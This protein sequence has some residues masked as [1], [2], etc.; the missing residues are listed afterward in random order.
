MWQLAAALLQLIGVGGRPVGAQAEAEAEAA[1]LRTFQQT[2]SAAAAAP[3]GAAQLGAAL[4]SAANALLVGL[5]ISL[6]VISIVGNCLVCVAIFTERKLRKL[7][8]AFIV[9]LAIADLFVSCLVMTFALCNELMSYWIF[10]DWF[11]DVWIS[12][13]IMCST[14]SIL[15]LCAISLDRFILIKDCLLYNQWMTRKVASV[16]LLLIW[17]ISALVS[18]L[19][20]FLGWHKPKAG[21]DY[22]SLPASLPASS[23]Q[24][25]SGVQD[26]EDHDN[27]DGRRPLDSSGGA[28]DA[29]GGRRP[30]RASSANKTASCRDKL[31][32]SGGHFAA[33]S[34]AA[35]ETQSSPPPP[36]ATLAAARAAQVAPRAAASNS[37]APRAAGSVSLA[38]GV[39]FAWRH[40]RARRRSR[41]RQPR[42]ANQRRRPA[43]AATTIDGSDDK[44]APLDPLRP[45]LVAAARPTN[46]AKRISGEPRRR[47]QAQADL[48]TQPR[49]VGG[50]QHEPAPLGWPLGAQLARLGAESGQPA[51]SPGLGGSLAASAPALALPQCQLSLTPTYAIVSST[52]SFYIPCII[53]IGLYTKLFACARR[54]VKSIQSISRAPAPRVAAD[55]NCSSAAQ[56][57]SLKQLHRAETANN[58]TAS[59]TQPSASSDLSSLGTGGGGGGGVATASEPTV[60]LAAGGN[61]SKP[62]DKN[63]EAETNID[64]APTAGSKASGRRRS[65]NQQRQQQQV[66]SPETTKYGQDLSQTDSRGSRSQSRVAFAAAGGADETQPFVSAGDGE[67]ETCELAKTTTTTIAADQPTKTTGER[68]APGQ[69]QHQHQNQHQIQ[70]R[71]A[72]GQQKQHIVQHQQQHGGGGGHLATHKAAITLGI[73]MGT[74]L[75]CW[76]PFFCLNIIKAF[77]GDCIP[78]SVFRFFTWLGYANSALNPIIYGIHNSEFRSAFNRVFFK[79]LRPKQN[80][81]A[82]PNQPSSNGGRRKQHHQHLR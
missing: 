76:V 17:F 35:I 41:R 8:N 47:R 75:F 66:H 36:A 23:R 27:Q 38:A 33:G 68:P 61:R 60:G 34:K 26:H 64:R 29:T 24:L 74:F 54:H 67:L 2:D 3:S 20:I 65:S 63:K 73:I 25:A 37:G 44:Q 5:L 82:G 53:M 77:C 70:F 16:A 46:Q 51:A 31:N 79:H 81:L 30:K 9:S 40:N 39:D 42:K 1:L 32:Y 55:S 21:T 7:G 14:A 12:F 6:I 52:I 15:N 57:C 11:C 28:G 13:D 71:L 18:F 78:G 45:A 4:A 69:S 22:A 56:S 58:N 72:S 62:A 10:G 43:A 19:P 48:D 50:A 59:S 80:P 49:A